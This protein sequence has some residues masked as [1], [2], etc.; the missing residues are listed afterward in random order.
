MIQGAVEETPLAH[1]CATGSL[2]MVKVLIKAGAELNF[3][4]SVRSLIFIIIMSI[5]HNCLL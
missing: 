5:Q 1:A 4:C 3:R 2:D